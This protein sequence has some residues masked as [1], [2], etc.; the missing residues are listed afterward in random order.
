[1]SSAALRG[2]RG[3]FGERISQ[4]H[5]WT[6]PLRSLPSSS[7]AK[8]FLSSTSC[9]P[10][11]TSQWLPQPCPQSGFLT[12]SLLLQNS[13]K[14]PQILPADHPQRPSPVPP[15][16]SLECSPG[17][18]PTGTVFRGPNWEGCLGKSGRSGR[19]GR[20]QASVGTGSHQG[21]PEGAKAN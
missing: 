15:A 21:G 17:S 6:L 19:A 9:C 18:P 12:P 3:E 8:T 14:K 20:G 4:V 2:P 16:W 10:P 11:L 7:P 13:G 5:F 1:M